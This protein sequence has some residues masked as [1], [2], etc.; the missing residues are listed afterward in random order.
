MNKIKT[1]LE[2][3]IKELETLINNKEDERANGVFSSIIEK[4]SRKNS[5]AVGLEQ[6][7]SLIREDFLL[8]EQNLSLICQF[9]A[10]N[11][12]TQS[13]ILMFLL[14]RNIPLACERDFVI[15]LCK[16]LNIK[17]L[18]SS[19]WDKLH[20]DIIKS[21]ERIPALLLDIIYSNKDPLVVRGAIFSCSMN[22]WGRKRSGGYE[23]ADKKV[24]Q[25]LDFAITLREPTVD[26]EILLSL[27]RLVKKYGSSLTLDVWEII[28]KIL[29]KLEIYSQDALSLL[30][31]QTS[32]ELSSVVYS[33]LDEYVKILNLICDIHKQGRFS[34][35]VWEF[36]LI[37]KNNRNILPENSV[38]YL[39]DLYLKYPD[40]PIDWNFYS[41]LYD[42]SRPN[43][44]RGIINLVIKLFRIAKCK[45]IEETFYSKLF[46]PLKNTLEA[47]KE[48]FVVYEF[49]YNLDF[50]LS[51]EE[52]SPYILDIIRSTILSSVCECENVEKFCKFKACILSLVRSC[53]LK[54]CYNLILEFIASRERN[55]T[56]GPCYSSSL[57][58]C[59]EALTKFE[60]KNSTFLYTLNGT[61]VISN[62]ELMDI[63]KYFNILLSMLK[64]E[65][66]S[67][68]YY[69]LLTSLTNNL[70]HRVLFM[71]F[72]QKILLLRSYLVEKI[73]TRMELQFTDPCVKRTEV[74]SSLFKAGLLLVNY[75][76]CF[77]KPLQDELILT[78]MS[79]LKNS[80][81]MQMCINSFNFLCL[82]MS[83]SVSKFLP[84]II[85]R[86]SQI[87]SS[88]SLSIHILEFLS[89]LSRFPRVY[90]N[91]VE[92][93]IK[94]I[95]GI[96]V[97][98][99][100]THQTIS[101]SP[102]AE[103]PFS[104]YVLSMAYNVIISWYTNLR[105]SER[106]K[107]THFIT[108]SIYLAHSID[109]SLIAEVF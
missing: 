61:E 83:P 101:N 95:F 24:L 21:P 41:A 46:F 109:E 96:A 70:K 31:V 13:L 36:C 11:V 45:N 9:S 99:I 6:T 105:V 104:Q 35:N 27:C 2:S 18:S 100:Q 75:K 22:S 76:H 5:K 1:S 20:N 67:C 62:V 28:L 15:F 108:R 94:K 3:E 29:Q 89:T 79:G 23:I 14:R 85:S 37:L 69:V 78:L 71:S 19:C 65:T 34:G 63:E 60:F 49:Y 107:Y 30:K 102:S 39:L 87:M 86:L 4:I 72:S 74:Y 50:F 57:A 7:L 56:L 90:A 48:D 25:S 26:F 47:E 106:K 103:N 40:I 77:S 55:D 54:S 91:L 64:S 98:Y 17:S 33:I 66:N 16:C 12:E 73:P 59:F 84:E 58:V 82:E 93:D 53:Y 80:V 32:T 44:R 38:L 51:F 43:I 92:T 81:T 52:N 88:I 68:L 10:F 8:S 42:D 97:L